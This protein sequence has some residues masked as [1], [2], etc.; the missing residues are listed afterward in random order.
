M[1]IFGC[2]ATTSE[3]ARVSLSPSLTD[4]R[5]GAPSLSLSLDRFRLDYRRK[6]EGSGPRRRRRCCRGITTLVLKLYIYY[7]HFERTPPPPPPPTPKT[8]AFVRLAK[9]WRGAPLPLARPGRSPDRLFASAALKG[10]RAAAERRQF[11]GR[12]SRG[13]GAAA[14]RRRNKIL[15]SVCSFAGERRKE[16]KKS[17]RERAMWTVRHGGL[18][19]S[20]CVDGATM[21][22]VSIANKLTSV[23]H[24][25]RG[26][27]ILLFC[28]KIG[29]FYFQLTSKHFRYVW[30]LFRSINVYTVK[31][32]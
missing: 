10:V 27:L 3:Q 13:R 7:V 17:E 32:Y 6:K 26:A 18:T 1:L 15:A 5:P 30:A 8:T 28:S 14:N 29:K 31:T 23:T 11:G 16:R 21:I 24:G 20:H 4:I 2:R 19:F 22:K 9:T 12:G 25:I